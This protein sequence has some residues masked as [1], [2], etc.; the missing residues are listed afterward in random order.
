MYTPMLSKKG[1]AILYR[2]DHMADLEFHFPSVAR[3][4]DSVT[5]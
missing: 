3:F 1:T 2:Q 4:R 5:F